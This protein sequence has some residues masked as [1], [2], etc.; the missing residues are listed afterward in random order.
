MEEANILQVIGTGA[1]LGESPV[2]SVDDQ[3]LYW[4]DIK[5]PALHRYDPAS[6]KD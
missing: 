1:I 6:G 4:L 5:A 3:V 2:W